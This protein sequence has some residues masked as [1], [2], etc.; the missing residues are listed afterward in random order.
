MILVD[1]SVWVAHFRESVP[2][3]SELLNENRVLM[4]PSVI[5]ELAC[6]TLPRRSD[7]LRWL[8]RIPMAEVANDNEVLTLIDEKH[9]WGTGIGWV[10]THLLASGLITGSEVWTRDERLRAAAKR[11]R[12]AFLGDNF[13]Q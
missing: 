10:D 2:L 6:G 8:R 9:L 13:I 7:V 5:G 3:L 4:H 1:T 12:L 11:L